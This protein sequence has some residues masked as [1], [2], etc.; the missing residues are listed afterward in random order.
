[1]LQQELHDPESHHCLIRR[2]TKSIYVF[3]QICTT[4]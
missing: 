2:S 1:M 3:G 4:R